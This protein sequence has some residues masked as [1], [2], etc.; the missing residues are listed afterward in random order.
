PAPT[1][2]THGVS[3]RGSPSSWTG[4]AGGVSTR[5]SRPWAYPMRPSLPSGTPSRTSYKIARTA[6]PNDHDIE[7]AVV[8]GDAG[9]EPHE[10]RDDLPAVGDQDHRG[11]RLVFH[12][13]HGDQ[14]LDAAHLGHQPQGRGDVRGEPPAVLVQRAG[15]G[16]D[17]P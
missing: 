15:A 10:R 13:I 17:S 11:L 4:S 12:A 16:H 9:T 3:P 2:P 14:V 7:Q 1:L 5:I 8:R 6:A